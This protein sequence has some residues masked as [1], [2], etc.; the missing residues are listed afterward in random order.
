MKHF[1]TLTDFAKNAKSV[2]NVAAFQRGRR[3]SQAPKHFTEAESELL[4]SKGQIVYA[5]ITCKAAAYKHVDSVQ[6]SAGLVLDLLKGQDVNL[7]SCEVL[8][9]DPWQDKDGKTHAT[10]WVLA[11]TMSLKG[12]KL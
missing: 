2:I 12:L 8:V 5:I 7:S 11:P 10:A 3:Y 4:L 1:K 9:E 6:L